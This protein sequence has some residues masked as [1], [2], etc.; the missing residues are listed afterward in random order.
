MQPM[1]GSWFLKWA[2]NAGTMGLGSSVSGSDDLQAARARVEPNET[3]G[4][5]CEQFRSFLI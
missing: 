1:G 2:I 3:E 5:K 4:V